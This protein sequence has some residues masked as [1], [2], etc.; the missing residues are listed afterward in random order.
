MSPTEIITQGSW[1]HALF[2]TYA[3]SLSFYET[4]LHKLG[5][6]QNG[7]RDI[8][9]IAD[10]DGYQLS[11]SERQSHRVGNEYRLIPA[12]L[13]AGVFHP[14]IAWLA[15]K[16][17][18]LLL[19]GSGNLTFGG[20]GKN[21]ECLQVVRSDQHP[22]LFGQIEDLLSSC[23][24]R[25]DLR[26][27]EVGW[28]DFW[29]ER[30]RLI[31]TQKS[32]NAA[33]DLSLLHSTVQPIG[34][35]I[36]ER[37]LQHGK[38]LEVR[39]LSPYYDPDARGI[40]DFAASLS[41]P[42]LTIGL[43]P[44][45]GTDT[46]FP[47][48]HLQSATCQISAA[49][50]DA[51]EDC[52]Q[53]HA[54]VLEICMDDG[55][56]FLV[57]GSVNATRK[58]L[59]TS[60]NIET[61]VLRHYPSATVRPFV[62]TP[63]SIPPTARHSEF[64]RAGLGNRVVVSARLT[65]DG[66][67]EGNL[68]LSRDPAGEWLGS[69]Q[70]IDGAATGLSLTVDAQGRFSS[71]LDEVAL[72]QHATGLQLHVSQH[73][74]EG[75][76]W[77]SVEGLLMAARRGFLSPSTL[78]R[79]L[80]PEADESD[81]S[82][83]LRYLATSAQRHLPAFTSERKVSQRG[84]TCADDEQGKGDLAINL[85][86][87][88]LSAGARRTGEDQTA[89]SS[90]GEEAMLNAYMRRIRQ[91]LL[92]TTVH[93]ES[94]EELE[95]SG[96]D[97]AAKREETERHQRRQQL[98]LSLKGFREKLRS[99]TES[100]KPGSER[101]AAAC[102]WFEVSLAMLLRRLNEPDEAEL[103]MKDWLSLVLSGQR[104]SN[105]PDTLTR[106]V[107]SALLA[108]G[109]IEL[110]RTGK[111]GRTLA[112]LREQLDAFCEAVPSRELFLELDLLDPSRPPLAGEML[113]NLPAAPSLAETLDKML[114]TATTRQQLDLILGAQASGAVIPADLPVLEVL[115][116]REFLAQ[117]QSGGQPKMRP[118]SSSSSSCTHC[119]LKLPLGTIREIDR[120][121]LGTCPNCGRFL[122]AIV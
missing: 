104:M 15:G 28:L 8:Q 111:P 39:S 78:L 14:K 82:E 31:K 66:K 7:C 57:T 55:S 105:S 6:A 88:L 100:L 63:T 26:F 108:L 44:G 4:Q 91:N 10:V 35:Q 98:V 117:V 107:L 90:S 86:L 50:F 102:M 29:T 68:I 60:D 54:K 74:S 122:I 3:L 33:M 52:R 76:G 51:P 41:A 65:G 18:D 84:T 115:A 47:F 87:D 69:L 56:A 75:S 92:R 45:R 12:A 114:A 73:G 103:F 79:L 80:G 67:I 11:L 16:Q 106:H 49:L 113:Q 112:R 93:A 89:D 120:D 62:W 119:H 94:S 97:K 101:S 81:E 36:S 53:L 17:I 83:L 61:A 40:L 77:V 109:S 121:R 19:L 42:K 110:Q 59:M 5:L 32:E 2:T 58:S 37:V 38:I 9:I 43:L 64:T 116:G 118:V 99:L 23:K 85:P 34:H 95:E 30:A 96:D 72:F 22:A 1:T 48:H 25:H 71:D 70:R 21:V 13:P 24:S 46:T 20:Y 27:P